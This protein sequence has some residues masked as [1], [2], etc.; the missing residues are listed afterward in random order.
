MNDAFQEEQKNL[1]SSFDKLK[2]EI[3]NIFGE[4]TLQRPNGNLKMVI[5]KIPNFTECSNNTNFNYQPNN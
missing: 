4:E 1:I 5:P 3:H 2:S